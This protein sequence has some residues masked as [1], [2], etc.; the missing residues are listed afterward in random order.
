MMR[1]RTSALTLIT[2][3]VSVVVQTSTAASQGLLSEVRGLVFLG[4]PLHPP[5]RPGNQRADHLFEVSLPML[6]LQVAVDTGDVQHG[7]CGN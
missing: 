6:F 1:P 3:L 2:L 7:V 5:N 4:F